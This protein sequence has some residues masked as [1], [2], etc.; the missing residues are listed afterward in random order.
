MIKGEQ[1]KKLNKLKTKKSSNPNHNHQIS[2]INRVQGQLTGIKKMI[3]ERRY[4]P[5]IIQQ[6]RATRKALYGIEAAL[7]SCHMKQCVSDAIKKGHIDEREQ[8]LAEIMQIFK[9]A[10]SQGIEF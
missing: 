6:V 2:K 10:S 7:L 3:E 8:K 1:I 4:C 5:E 9:S